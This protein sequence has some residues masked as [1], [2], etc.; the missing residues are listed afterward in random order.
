[1]LRRVV[2]GIFSGPLQEGFSQLVVAHDGNEDLSD[3]GFQQL[4]L[5]RAILPTVV[6]LAA[7]PQRVI[8]VPCGHTEQHGYHLPMNTDT[9]IIGTIAGQVTATIPDE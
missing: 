9:V 1:M 3:T 6:P 5:E 4:Y 7:T 8:L 2:S